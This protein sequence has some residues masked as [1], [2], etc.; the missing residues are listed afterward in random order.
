MQSI[1]GSACGDVKSAIII[2][3]KAEV[4]GLFGHVNDAETIGS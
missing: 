2:I 4:S 3:T 1:K